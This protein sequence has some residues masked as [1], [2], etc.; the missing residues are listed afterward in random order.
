MHATAKSALGRLTALLM[1]G[2]LALMATVALS[3]SA[4]AEDL[5]ATSDEVVEA[6]EA[7][8]WPEYGTGDQH[9]DVAAAKYLLQGQGYDPHLDQDSPSE[10]DARTEASVSAFQNDHG[11]HDDGR[12]NAET[13]ESL[14]QQAFGEYGP[15][16]TGDAVKATQF[17]LNAKFYAHIPVDGQYGP[18]T[19]GNVTGAQEHFDIAADGIVGPVTWRALVTYDDHDR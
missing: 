12:L 1:T 13:W 7:Q 17:L 4:S 15:G 18:N 9:P 11:L 6:I 5:R 16:S 3:S 8:P 2:S 19:A 14:R 10:F